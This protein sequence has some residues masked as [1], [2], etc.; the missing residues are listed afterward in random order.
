MQKR[1][2]TLT[3]N[4]KLLLHEFVVKCSERSLLEDI[5]D[6]TVAKLL[7]DG[8]LEKVSEHPSDDASLGGNGKTTYAVALKEREWRWL[9]MEKNRKLL[10]IADN[11]SDA[12]RQF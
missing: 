1:Y 10:E 4:E 2:K 5:S 6:P 3:K 12:A 8:I 7:H 9:N 11:Q